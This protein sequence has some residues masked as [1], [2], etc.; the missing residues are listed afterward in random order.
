MQ[1]GGYNHHPFKTIRRAFNNFLN[2]NQQMKCANC[3]KQMTAQYLIKGKK[4]VCGDCIE[5]IWKAEDIEFRASN[6]LSSQRDTK[7]NHE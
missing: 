7:T 3:P 4:L 1:Y 5:K 6:S 2:E